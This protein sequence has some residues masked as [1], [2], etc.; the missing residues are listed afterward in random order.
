[1]LSIRLSETERPVKQ[2]T[3]EP[4]R[5][6]FNRKSIR[7][8][9][10]KDT[11]KLRFATSEQSLPMRP[12]G[13]PQKPVTKTTLENCQSNLAQVLRDLEHLS[14]LVKCKG[15]TGKEYIRRA[16]P[17]IQKRNELVQT[18]ADW[19]EPRDTTGNI[20][21]KLHEKIGGNADMDLAESPGAAE[22]PDAPRAAPSRL[23]KYNARARMLSRVYWLLYPDGNTS[24]EEFFIQ[25]AHI[26]DGWVYHRYFLPGECTERTRLTMTNNILEIAWTES[27]D[28]I[29][30]D[31]TVTRLATNTDEPDSDDTIDPKDIDSARYVADHRG[32]ES[33]DPFWMESKQRVPAELISIDLDETVLR[34]PALEI[35]PEDLVAI[36]VNGKTGY[37]TVQ[38]VIT[39]QIIIET[40][41]LP[42]SLVD[43]LMLSDTM[44]IIEIKPHR[45]NH[46]GAISETESIYDG[47]LSEY[48]L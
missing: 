14:L 24:G 40:A 25:T 44:P 17:L 37:A 31:R 41:D 29:E 13:I 12:M 27:I 10:G 32:L 9:K 30:N 36:T 33:Y 16:T 15:I 48:V 18:L 2:K 22:L 20:L 47:N 6:R 45:R 26:M 42:D 38:W 39:D 35:D 46:L 8:Q 11:G 21:H 43:E 4:R 19:E 23:P 3:N 34:A 7:F 1:M 28:P 5:M